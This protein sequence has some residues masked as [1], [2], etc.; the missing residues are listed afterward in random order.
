M[1]PALVKFSNINIYNYQCW[2]FLTPQAPVAQCLMAMKVPCIS[3]IPWFTFQVYSTQIPSQY[4]LVWECS[5]SII[6]F[7]ITWINSADRP[8]PGWCGRNLNICSEHKL[9]IVSCSDFMFGKNWQLL[10]TY[11]YKTDVLHLIRKH[12][13]IHKVCHPLEWLLLK[14]FYHLMHSSIFFGLY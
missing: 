14:H 3:E 7:V 13:S 10:F 2:S 6:F 11:T 12:F 5:W 1:S 9:Q 4:C 8:F